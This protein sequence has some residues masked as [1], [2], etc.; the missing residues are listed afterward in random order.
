MC[1]RDS[2]WWITALQERNGVHFL[3]HSSDLVLAMDASTNGWMGNLPGLGAF[4]FETG[5][6][7][8]GPPPQI[9]LHLRIEDLELLCHIVSCNI[10][11]SQWSSLRVLG[12]TDNK[13]CF[14][15]L[16]NGRS[17]EDLRLRM[18]R[19]VAA[20]QV[21]HDFLWTAE[22]LSTHENKIPDALSRWSSDKHKT[23]FFSECS[24]LGITPKKIDLLD[25]HFF[26]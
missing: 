16:E 8:H 14:Y 18:A 3:E 11:S 24:R 26:F 6:Y 17:R 2:K 1:I 21:Q 25:E 12:K 5:E 4:N 15:L 23:M 10:W 22:W 19:F 20:K 7:W 9:Y 13:S